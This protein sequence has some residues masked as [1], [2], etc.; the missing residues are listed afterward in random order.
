MSTL[1]QTN[2]T[3]T[4]SLNVDENKQP[5]P[6]RSPISFNLYSKYQTDEQP[7]LYIKSDMEVVNFILTLP[8]TTQK[9]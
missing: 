4:N 8:I 7:V 9:H 1:N 6:S 3:S 5:F 2:D